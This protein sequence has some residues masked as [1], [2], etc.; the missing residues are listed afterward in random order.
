MIEAN[1]K[2]E[3]HLEW[4]TVEMRDLSKAHNVTAEHLIDLS[5][6]LAVVEKRYLVQ[7]VQVKEYK[8]VGM[9]IISIATFLIGT[10]ITQTISQ[11]FHKQ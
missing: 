6:R 7:D 8:K 5:N 9:W 11:W 10:F 3:Q 2:Q 1:D 4:M